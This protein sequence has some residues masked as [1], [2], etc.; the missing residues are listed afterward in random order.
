MRIQAPCLITPQTRCVS[1]HTPLA[2][3]PMDAQY[4]A[5]NS[6]VVFEDAH[7]IGPLVVWDSDEGSE[8]PLSLAQR[9][10]LMEIVER[11]SP[12]WYSDTLLQFLISPTDVVSGAPSLRLLDWFVTNYAKSRAVVID[13]CSIHAEYTAV[14]AAYQCRNFDPFRRNLKLTLILPDDPTRY[15]TAVSQVNF[16]YWAHETGVLKYVE[17]HRNEIEHDMCTVYQATRRRREETIETGK[18]RK[19]QSLSESGGVVCRVTRIR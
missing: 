4:R 1:V 11:A 2:S 15:S 18:K 8:W 5:A 13:G 17:Q 16:I 6:P 14:R 12:D 10:I 3:D 19:R 7:Q 9:R